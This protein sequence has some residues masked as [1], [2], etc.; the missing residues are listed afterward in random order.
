MGVECLI[1]QL[2]KLLMHYE[3]KS[4]RGL[5]L[6][7]SLECIMVELGLSGQLFQGSYERHESWV[8][9]S[10]LMSWWEKYAKFKIQVA[11]NDVSI[12][13]QRQGN[14]WLM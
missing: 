9:S 10:W 4:N 11:S 13:A 14:Q 3:C 6:K 1:A 2:N 8:T 12:E 5:K 7:L